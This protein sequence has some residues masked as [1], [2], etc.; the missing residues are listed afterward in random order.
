MR[1][2][3]VLAECL[4]HVS[5]RSAPP[6]WAA[7]AD[8]LDAEH[9][10]LQALVRDPA[11]RVYGANTLM[12]HRDAE[13]IPNPEAMTAEI[14]RTHAI[15]A[16]PWH[17]RH[18][19][20]CIGYAKLYS[21]A[22]GLSGVSPELFEG[23]SELVTREDFNPQVPVGASY[24]C[25]DVIPASHWAKA[26]LD[27]L[28]RS[29]FHEVRPGEAMALINGSF[30]HVG[31]AVAM[32][33][34]L[35]RTSALAVEAAA[36]FHSAALANPSNLYFVATAE[37][38]WASKAVRYVA[39]RSRRSLAATGTQDPVSLR[40]IPQVLETWSDAV[41]DF[42]G[43]LNY[44]LFKPSCNPFIDERYAFPISQASFLAPT[45]SVKTGGVIEA[46]LFLMWALLG[47]TSHLLSG[48]VPDIPRD[49][50]TAAS[51]LGQIQRPK[52]MTAICEKARMDLGRRTF[53]AGSDT[54]YG[55]EDI[56]TNGVFTLAQ[57]K[58]ALDALESM[59]C[60]SVWTIRRLADD[61]G[62]ARV[63]GSEL[64]DACAGCSTS[65]EAAERLSAALR[66]GCPREAHQL[67]WNG[68]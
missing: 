16:P 10:H 49:G 12:G 29:G 13:T 14:L 48:R 5:N 51:P 20:R 27:E 57:L 65:A 15:A 30:V 11:V 38:A 62:L 1:P 8:R 9:R 53:A 47:W 34:N 43:E 58:C 28:S 42:L 25:G 33:S 50:S 2:V 54:S 40:A 24:S 23:V 64:L 52:L 22:A 6:L 56:W 46:A 60:Q 26:V 45:L 55:I 39:D 68:R 35:Q 18:T 61:F 7:G 66:E 67:F 63:A 41:G 37:R 36:L 3:G 32:V 21:W 59:F 19:A 31:L 4:D 44:L 17:D